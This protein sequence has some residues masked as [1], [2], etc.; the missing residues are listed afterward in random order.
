MTQYWTKFK[1]GK[2]QLEYAAKLVEKGKIVKFEVSSLSDEFKRIYDITYEAFE[3]G[4]DVIKKLELKN[5][6]NFYPETIKNQFV[7]DLQNIKEFGEIEWIFNKTDV[8]TD[9]PTL[10]TKV[11]G[12]LNVKD[13]DGIPLNKIKELLGNSFGKVDDLNKSEKLLKALN[14]D[15]IFESIFKIAE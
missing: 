1:G 14:D 7:K 3:N 8:I 13:L 15:S 10:K 5:W 4:R 2:F 9:I 6:N 11:M 12:A